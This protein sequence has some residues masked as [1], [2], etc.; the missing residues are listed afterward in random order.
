MQEWSLLLVSQ[1]QRATPLVGEGLQ[2]PTHNATSIGIMTLR[3][4]SSP[5]TLGVGKG[6]GVSKHS[7][8]QT[9][10]PPHP[11]TART[12][13]FTRRHKLS[14][15]LPIVLCSAYWLLILSCGGHS[16]FFCFC[17]HLQLWHLSFL[18]PFHKLIQQNG[19]W[20]REETKNHYGYSKSVWCL[21]FQSGVHLQ[22]PS[23]S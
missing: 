17:F 5:P 8:L 15:L 6:V 22:A 11:P 12:P 13:S 23:S 10:P 18:V 7:E 20:G 2:Q 21:R 1:W 9:P 16:N 19:P 14:L 4:H 3:E